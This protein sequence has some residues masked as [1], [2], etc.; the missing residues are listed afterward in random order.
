MRY[1]DLTDSFHL[2]YDLKETE[3]DKFRFNYVFSSTLLYSNSPCIN[4]LLVNQYVLLEDIY[5][6]LIN[7]R[8]ISAE[9]INKFINRNYKRII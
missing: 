8:K 4:Y 6:T 7:F 9:Y 5:I 2:F 1:I 3:N